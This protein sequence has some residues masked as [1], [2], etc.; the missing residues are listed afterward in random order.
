MQNND[1]TKTCTEC[2]KFKDGELV[3]CRGY[4]TPEWTKCVFES[5]KNDR[6]TSPYRVYTE[7]YGTYLCYTQC[8]PYAGNEHLLGTT[9]KPE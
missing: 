9:G 3:L 8:I 2:G 6:N 5:F 4:G 7:Y 1:D